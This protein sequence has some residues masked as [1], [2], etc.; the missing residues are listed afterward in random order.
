MLVCFLNDHASG[1]GHILQ[2]IYIAEE[3]IDE[4]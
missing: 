3:L 4:L 1:L 2:K